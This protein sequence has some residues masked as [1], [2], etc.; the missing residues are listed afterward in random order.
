[1][2]SETIFNDY[3][4]LKNMYEEQINKLKHKIIMNPSLS[5]KEKKQ[6][7]KELKPKCI[8]CKRPVGSIF[9]NKYNNEKSFRE[10][11]ATCGSISD[12][13]NFKILIEV[14]ETINVLDNIIDL[15]KELQVE[16]NNIIENK[17]KLLFGY[18]NTEESLEKFDKMKTDV[19]DS[20]SFLEYFLNKYNEVVDNKE[21][22]EE[23]KKLKEEVF[24][25]YI[26]SIKNSI[27]EF[28]KT[29][30][31]KFIL[32]A[33][34]IYVN[35]LTP[36][37]KELMDLKYKYNAVE[38]NADTNTFHLIQKK[39]T[40][41]D[42]EYNLDEP[43]LIQ[44]NYG[45]KSKTMKNKP[46]INNKSKTM[47]NK[48]TLIIEDNESIEQS[49]NRE[50]IMERTKEVDNEPHYNQDMTIYW[51]NPEY[52]NIWSKLS[53]KYKDLLANDKEWLQNTMDTY[54]NDKKQNKPIH[55]VL[56]E[57]LIIPPEHLEDGNFNFGNDYIN[58]IFNAIP[59]FQKEVL[60]SLKKNI[61]GKDDYT[62]FKNALGDNI[63][64]KEL[65][66]N[67]ELI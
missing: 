9:S 31:T 56:P 64:A 40:I 19:E 17:N 47:K 39:Y 5:I 12:P 58:K 22:N 46:H 32:D 37:L 57:N 41:K 48:P 33:V 54:V 62:M 55:F 30:N 67:S 4:K 34:D 42:M 25:N 1:M 8:N 10:L 44:Y 60:L 35:T 29:H 27:N 15:E 11:R 45:L 13:C 65:G 3:Y 2:T 51:N 21:I 66:F 26:I 7:F 43:K 59:S 49:N 61:N 28:D 14:P 23:I 63:L 52:Q 16:K 6:E 36:K 50:S 38:F 24:N 18:L 20:T 53:T